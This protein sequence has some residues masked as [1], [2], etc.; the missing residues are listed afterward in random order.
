MR[1]IS[2]R[3]CDFVCRPLLGW[4]GSRRP[5]RSM[6]ELFV[7]SA[8]LGSLSSPRAFDLLNATCRMVAGWAGGTDAYGQISREWDVLL[9]HEVAWL[10]REHELSCV[11]EAAGNV[12]TRWEEA[13][14]AVE[15]RRQER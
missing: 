11:R 7:A 5:D 6:R 8:W 15:R 3:P 12:L 14:V 9:A 13:W 1:R 2:A 4:K 10:M